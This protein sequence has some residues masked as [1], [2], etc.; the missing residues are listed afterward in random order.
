MSVKT[1]LDDLVSKYMLNSPTI[2]GVVIGY[3]SFL[4]T[5]A[6]RY[7]KHPEEVGEM[8]RRDLLNVGLNLAVHVGVPVIAGAGS[9]HV[10][11]EY[12][13]SRRN[14][15]AEE[16]ARNAQKR[17]MEETERIYK[18]IVGKLHGTVQSRFLMAGMRLGMEY[19]DPDSMP[20]NVNIIIFHIENN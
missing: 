19:P 13:R 3:T 10:V 1:K 20:E 8:L 17:I 15:E 6:F 14:I 12:R 2:S 4:T 18:D 7:I 11:N 16:E 5:L 9:A